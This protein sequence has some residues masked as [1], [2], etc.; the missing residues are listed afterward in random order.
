MLNQFIK[1]LEKFLASKEYKSIELTRADALKLYNAL[2]PKIKKA[3]K[4]PGRPRTVKKA[5]KKPKKKVNNVAEVEY[6]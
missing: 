2:K 6:V 4:K 3:V 5:T 1:L